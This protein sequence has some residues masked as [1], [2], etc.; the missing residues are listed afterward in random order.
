M[1]TYEFCDNL[2]TEH[3]SN[4]AIK[5]AIIQNDHEKVRNLISEMT[6]NG[7]TI[8]Q[9]SLWPI[10]SFNNNDREMLELILQ[11]IDKVNYY[12]ISNLISRL[13]ISKN[14][15][16][17]NELADILYEYKEKISDPRIIEELY[18]PLNRYWEGKIIHK[19]ISLLD[20]NEFSELL[21]PLLVKLNI[22]STQKPFNS[23][24]NYN[25]SH[26][27]IEWIENKLFYETPFPKHVQI[28]ILNKI[29][30]KIVAPVALPLRS[31][32]HYFIEPIFGSII[33]THD[34]LANTLTSLNK[35][36]HLKEVLDIT[37]LNC[38]E[39]KDYCIMVAD[40]I[41]LH[42][43]N[44]NYALGFHY[45]NKILLSNIKL[46][47]AFKSL[48]IH[49][50][51]HLAM[52]E[53]FKNSRNPYKEEDI[54]AKLFYKQSISNT[55]KNICETF[56]TIN[57]SDF[58]NNYEFG[59]L[60]SNQLFKMQ[61]EKFISSSNTDKLIK[62]YYFLSKILSPYSSSYE[63]EEE[64][65]EFIVHYEEQV[66]SGV[67]IEFLNILSPLKEYIDKFIKPAMRDYIDSHPMDHLLTRT[68]E[69]PSKIE[70]I[71]YNENEVCLVDS[72]YYQLDP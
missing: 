42:H 23:I 51:W 30:Q 59:K 52:S 5:N 70:D 31:L 8:S 11:S 53:I 45:N 41:K 3:N 57:C 2:S 47:S 68:P 43:P 65:S 61:F 32:Y 18:M 66:A 22:L 7:I 14:T 38:I 27:N 17:L 35:N 71:V 54:E 24:N 46:T 4:C 10:F 40:N 28:T 15:T 13:F 9:G 34:K 48:L 26:T 50:S 6:T 39:S 36:P 33:D 20:Y 63:Q 64:D 25:S 21:N 56:Y 29:L 16:N 72:V 37:A 62:E 19:S 44:N 55:L 58:N 69:E 60:L 67:S 12:S 49:E 1:V